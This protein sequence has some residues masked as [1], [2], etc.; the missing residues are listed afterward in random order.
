MTLFALIALF[1]WMPFVVVLFT[2]MPA[3]QAAAT[4]VIGAWLLLPPYSVAIAGLP[5]F[6]KNMSAA[7]GVM[8]GTILFGSSFVLRFRPRW[9][10]LPMLLLCCSVICTSL[11]NG[12]GLYDGL[13][14]ASSEVLW[15]GLP[16]LAGRLYFSDL[17]GLAFSPL[18]WSLAACCTSCR[19]NGRCE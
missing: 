16:Y 15:W 17:E 18:R 4:A 1:G 5:D 13:A 11:Y 6:S 2:I 7:I 19:A 10:D 9:F 8:L 14:A 12:L 3:R